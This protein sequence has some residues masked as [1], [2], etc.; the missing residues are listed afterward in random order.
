VAD[1]LIVAAGELGVPV[2]L[3]IGMVASDRLVHQS[4]SHSGTMGL[5]DSISCFSVTAANAASVAAYALSS[6][7][8]G[9]RAFPH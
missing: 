1:V 7:A 5:V 6:S 9:R 8:A 3:L 2:L 4:T